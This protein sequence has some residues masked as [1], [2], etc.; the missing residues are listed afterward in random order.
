[1]KQKTKKVST[2]QKTRR[3]GIKLKIMI[4]ASILILLAC[5]MLGVRAHTSVENGMVEMGIEQAQMIARIAASDVNSGLVAEL[6]P[7][8]EET[9]GYK[10]LLAKMRKI[11][12]QYDIAYLYT[13]YTDGE[14]VYYGV[15]AD[16]SQDQ[17]IVGDE[18]EVKYSEL[19]SA[20]SG[21]EYV[22]DF[23][24][25]TELGALVSAYEPITDGQGNVVGLLGC[26]YDAAKVVN[27]LNMMTKQIVIMT[28]ICIVIAMILFWFIVGRIVDGLQIVNS[29]IYDL[30]NNEGDLTQ[31]LDVKTGDELELI[32]NN[33]NHLLEYIRKI[34]LN[35]QHN[36]MQL[37]GSSKNVVQEIVSSEGSIS[38]VSSTMEQMSA[39]MEETSASLS[40]VNESVIQIYDVVEMI[41]NDADSGKTSSDEIMKKAEEIHSKAIEEQ[42][43]ARMQA[44]QMAEVVNEK[45]EKSKAVEEI[46]ILT[47]NILNITEQ[48]NLLALNASIEAARAGEAGKGFAVVAGEIGKLATD[49]AEAATQIQ[50]VSAEVVAAVNELAQKAEQMLTFMEEVAMSGYEKLLETSQNYQGDVGNMNDMMSRFATESEK[51]EESIN[52][53]KETIAAL[54]SAVEECTIGVTGVTETMVDLTASVGDIEQEADSNMNVANLLNDEVNKFKLE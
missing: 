15:D 19:A 6:E 30:V 4:P 34:M 48:T 12:G 38:D 53:I 51:A 21:E 43:D 39:A 9:K 2:K 8:C 22:Q 44:Q 46:N 29:K 11:Q 25:Y 7:G 45:I 33:V 27:R 54:N 17:S 40:Q 24:D 32:A 36:S 52:Q 23:I 37:T 1:M 26:D 35:I 16:S 28:V 5:V 49:S 14:K 50:S 31:H 13:L 20:F 41:A 47:A 3:M 18:F 10:T 42:K